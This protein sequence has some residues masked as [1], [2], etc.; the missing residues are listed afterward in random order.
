MQFWKIQVTICGVKRLCV[1]KGKSRSFGM[2]TTKKPAAK[3]AVTKAK[4][5]KKASRS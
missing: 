5:K 3:K 1:G 4:A 2:A